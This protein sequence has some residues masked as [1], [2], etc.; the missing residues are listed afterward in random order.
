LPTLEASRN[1]RKDEYC[2]GIFQVLLQPAHVRIGH[3]A[4]KR[5]QFT[6]AQLVAAPLTSPLDVDDVPISID[7]LVE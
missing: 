4:V 2:P 1:T 3:E 6:A 7:N 5:W